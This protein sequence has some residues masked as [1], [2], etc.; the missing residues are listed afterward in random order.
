[1]SAEFEPARGDPDGFQVHRLNH[2]ATTTLINPDRFNI[3]SIHVI[4]EQ[5]DAVEACWAHN[6][7]D[8]GSKPRYANT[9]LVLI[10]F[11][12]SNILLMIFKGSR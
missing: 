12:L 7:E 10:L 1:M 9:F 8:R 11:S 6:P 5:S 2:S 3:I 4:R